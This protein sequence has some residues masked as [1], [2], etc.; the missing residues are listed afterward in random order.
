VGPRR[1]SIEA[2]GAPCGGPGATTE[3]RTWDRRGG[4][5]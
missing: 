1:S 2:L 3:D 5:V 4:V